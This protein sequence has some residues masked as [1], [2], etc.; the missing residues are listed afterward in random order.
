MVFSATLIVGVTSIFFGKS[1]IYYIKYALE[2]HEHQGTVAFT[3]SLVAFLSIPFWW[4]VSN[5]IGKRKTWLISGSI[6]LSAFITF[7]FYPITTLNELL[8]LVAFLGLGSGAGGILFWS[9]LPDTIEYGEVNT[10][11]RSESSLYGFMTFAQKGSIAIAAA[12][13]T[14]AL[15]V[16]GFIPEQVQS[17]E[18]ISSMK[19]IMSLIPASGVVLSLIIIYFYP[20]DAQTHQDLVKKLETMNQGDI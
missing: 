15:T 3:G 4:T 8:F 7:Y 18:T 6:S 14:V 1:L 5:A 20:I 16:I 9:M 19:S 12:I 11:V 2:L 13:Y 17:A 10:G